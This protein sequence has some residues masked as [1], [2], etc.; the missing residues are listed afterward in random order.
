MNTNVNAGEITS[1]ENLS[2]WL[3]SA[4]PIVYSSLQQ[5]D[6]TEVLIIGG[7]IA[8]LSTAYNLVENGVGVILVED[9]NIGSGETVRTTA[10][11]TNALDD[12]YY[13]LEKLYGEDNT[14]LIA[15]SH[16]AAINWMENVVN[17]EQINCDFRRL[18]GYLF[19]HPSDDPDNLQL[20]LEAS[21]RAGLNTE[22]LHQIPFMEM[23]NSRC[24]KFPNQAQFHIMHYLQ[25]LSKAITD[26][27]G[28]I[29]TNSKADKIDKHG[30]EVNGH[31]IKAKHIVVATNTPVNNLFTMH[32]KQFAYRTY[33]IGALVPKDKIPYNL[34]WDTGN[35]DTK[36]IAAPYH[37]TRITAYD[38]A[39]DLLIVG[40]EDHKTGQGD[41]EN[42]TG[43]ERYIKLIEWAKQKFPAITETIFKWSGQV[44]EPVDGL[45][46][47]GRN[48]GDENIY[49]ITG[50]S[51]NGMTHGTLGGMIVSDLILGKKNEWEQ[52]Y[53]PARIT[54]KTTGEFLN[55]VGNMIA[56]YGDWISSGDIKEANELKPT[57]GAII[58]SGFKKVAA[59]RDE[60][61]QLHAFTAVCPHLGCIL[62]WNN[63]EKSFDC[64]CHGSRFTKEGVVINGPALTDLKRLEIKDE[65]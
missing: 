64:P 33:V 45:A 57:E 36:W 62:Q 20:E 44:M 34:W 31:T 16:T 14:K 23:E 2:Y 5:D 7:G 38:E 46:Y 27:G 41:D 28:K 47:L 15:N 54:L 58:T 48:P 26:K 53:D 61:N 40:G 11:L 52:L 19:S 65:G 6:D 51:G 42:I 9:G 55:E 22:M 1:G 18:N 29:F 35:Y 25:G 49:I 3:S 37:Y 30:A 13:E 17:T 8:G 32:T 12:R 50:D 10:H 39:N 59:Y 4:E 43:E 63:D 24:I 60:Q 21:L 56:Q